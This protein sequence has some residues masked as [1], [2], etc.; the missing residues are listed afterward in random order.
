MTANAGDI[1]FADVTAFHRGNVPVS[2]DRKII[3]F[4]FNVHEEYGLPPVD[5]KI[6]KKDYDKASH[7]VRPLLDDLKIVKE[8][9]TW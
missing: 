9:D 8:G 4:N 5:V 6:F 1:L 2:R 7:M 3:I